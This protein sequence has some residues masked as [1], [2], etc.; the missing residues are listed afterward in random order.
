MDAITI[1]TIILVIITAYY[2]W[3]TQRMVKEME[4]GRKLASM[5]MLSC[6]FVYEE[7]FGEGAPPYLKAIVRN[8]GNAPAIEATLKIEVTSPGESGLQIKSDVRSLHSIAN[9][10]ELEMYILDTREVRD[11]YSASETPPA[12]KLT[13]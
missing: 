13:M 6:E 9:G 2:A 4:R 1:A 5:P 3:Q 12:I 10:S 8:G 7:A 11:S